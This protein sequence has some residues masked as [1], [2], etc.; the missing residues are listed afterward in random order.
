MESRGDI[1][2]QEGKVG[3]TVPSYEYLDLQ[4]IAIIKGLIKEKSNVQF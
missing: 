2:M 4:M 3:V 1:M